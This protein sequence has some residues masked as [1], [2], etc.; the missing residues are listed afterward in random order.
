MGSS[1]KRPAKQTYES[2]T[3]TQ[4]LVKK[5]AKIKPKFKTKMQMHNNSS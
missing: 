3:N 2:T 4:T 1:K 5:L